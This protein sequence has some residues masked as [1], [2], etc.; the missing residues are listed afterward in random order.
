MKTKQKKTRKEHWSNYKAI[1]FLI[2]LTLVGFGIDLKYLTFTFIGIGFVA[3][4]MNVWREIN[5][6]C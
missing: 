4:S 5:D 2:G 1:T 3:I 6:F